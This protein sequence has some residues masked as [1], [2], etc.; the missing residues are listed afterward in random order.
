MLKIVDCAGAGVMSLIGYY[1]LKRRKGWI[2]ELF[3]GKRR[4]S[5]GKQE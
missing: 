5:G 1:S 3:S 4:Q 2:R